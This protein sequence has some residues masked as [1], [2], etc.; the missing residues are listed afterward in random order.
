MSRDHDGPMQIPVDYE[1]D[2]HLFSVNI[3]DG[4]D[5]NIEYVRAVSTEGAIADGAD[6]FEVDKGKS[7]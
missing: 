2:E 3:T 5:D 7:R 1:L 6:R 4:D